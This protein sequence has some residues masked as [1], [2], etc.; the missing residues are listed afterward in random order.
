M[1]SR[2]RRN[3]RGQPASIDRQ[4]PC[5]I[6]GRIHGVPRTASEFVS[7]PSLL[8]YL[9]STEF[10]PSPSDDA[11]APSAEIRFRTQGYVDSKDSK[12]NKSQPLPDL[13]TAIIH[14]YAFRNSGQVFRDEDWKR[15]KKI[16]T[17]FVDLQTPVL[18]SSRCRHTGTLSQPGLAAMRPRRDSYSYQGYLLTRH[19][20]GWQPRRGEDWRVWRW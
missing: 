1:V 5:P 17:S 18:A 7:K 8:S 2:L 19:F 13:K 10:S 4:G 12:V 9:T 15:L 6:F 3:C 11:G 16:G 14:E 20:S